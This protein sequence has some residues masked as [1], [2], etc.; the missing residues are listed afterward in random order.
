MLIGERERTQLLDAADQIE[1]AANYIRTLAGES[2]TGSTDG[3]IRRMADGGLVERSDALCETAIEL[4]SE[5]YLTLRTVRR[6]AERGG[7][8]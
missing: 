7:S 8:E 1:H 5:V 3:V 6:A 4:V 2:F